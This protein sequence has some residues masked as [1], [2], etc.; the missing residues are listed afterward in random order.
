MERKPLD[1]SAENIAVQKI[2]N[3]NIKLW[4]YDENMQLI[5]FLKMC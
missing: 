2:P 3:M 5:V 4:R 1:K